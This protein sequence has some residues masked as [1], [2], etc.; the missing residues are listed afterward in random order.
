MHMP[1]VLAIENFHKKIIENELD[2]F[3]L[4]GQVLQQ[5]LENRFSHF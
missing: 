4:Y 1:L 2:L 3:L 5:P